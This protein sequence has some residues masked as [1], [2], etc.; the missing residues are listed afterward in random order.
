MQPFDGYPGEGRLLLGRI[1]TG[2]ARQGYGLRLA[3]LTGATACAYCG[4]SFIDDYYHW[5]LLQ[6]DHVV[7][8]SVA[9]AYAIPKTFYEDAINMVLACSGCNS[10][11]NRY[12][13][14]P[15]HAGEW[16]LA[17]FVALRE[18]IFLERSRVIAERR[19]QELEFFERVW[20]RSV[21]DT[22]N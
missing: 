14:V 12:L 1:G 10:F 20:L 19:V 16:S 3:Q 13:H 9:G 8:V 17:A 2:N 21:A 22:M 6:V 5:L 18:T 15:E 4:V 11:K 7:P